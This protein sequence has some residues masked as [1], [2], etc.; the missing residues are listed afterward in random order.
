MEIPS[1]FYS[2][3]S[4]P[5]TE[6]QISRLKR[7]TDSPLP[8]DYLEFLS[9]YGG[10][11]ISEAYSHIQ[12]E[13]DKSSLLEVEATMIF[14]NIA[15]IGIWEN[16]IQL[17]STWL[18]DWAFYFCEASNPPEDKIL[19][20]LSNEKF[21][22]GSVLYEDEGK[23]FQVSENFTSF[24]SLLTNNRRDQPETHKDISDKFGNFHIPGK[25]IRK[26][27]FPNPNADRDW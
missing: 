25:T 14:G 18:H 6:E 11:I 16:S 5:F 22:I 10:G 12:L 2:T 27:E 19:L 15:P 9:L 21:K 8:E 7:S 3:K 23:I 1:D 24:I 13:T 20:N 17:D 4:N 26:I